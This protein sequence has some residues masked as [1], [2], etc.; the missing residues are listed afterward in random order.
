MPV[1]SNTVDSLHDEIIFI[2]SL[3][4]EQDGRDGD[5]GVIS[6]KLHGFGFSRKGF[7]PDLEEAAIP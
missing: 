6:D 7:G 1:K 2:V 5:C 4:D 3:E